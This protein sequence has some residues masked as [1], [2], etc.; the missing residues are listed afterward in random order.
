MVNNGKMMAGWQ[1]YMDLLCLGMTPLHQACVDGNLSAVQLLVSHD[2]DVNK[3]DADTWTAL[4]A[5]C[6]A[7]HSDIAR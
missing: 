6:A 4:H 1:Y 5:A 2:A 7:G 3:Q